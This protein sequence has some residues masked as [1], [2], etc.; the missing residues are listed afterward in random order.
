MT[1]AS[2]EMGAA[3]AREIAKTSAYVIVLDLHPPSQPF[4]K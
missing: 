3:I 4:G 1:G 2:N